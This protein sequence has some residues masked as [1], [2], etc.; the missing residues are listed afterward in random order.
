MLFPFQF[1]HRVLDP[2]SLQ[3]PLQALSRGAE[4]VRSCFTSLLLRIARLYHF[5]RFDTMVT[6][7][8]FP[9]NFRLMRFGGHGYHAF[10]AV[11]YGYTH[12]VAAGMDNPEQKPEWSENVSPRHVAESGHTDPH[13]GSYHASRT[14]GA[15]CVP[16]VIK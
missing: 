15:R 1:Q 4:Q 14:N 6:S 5:I 12:P 10:S 2:Q 3:L 11:P 7:S 13:F 16:L 9:L 8:P